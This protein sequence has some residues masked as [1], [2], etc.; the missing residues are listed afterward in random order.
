MVG[1]FLAVQFALPLS[2]Y[3]SGNPLDER[4]AWRMFS[5]IRMVHC[6]ATFHE[7][8]PEGRRRL[9]LGKEVPEVWET[10]VDRG[11]T[12]V[13]REVGEHICTRRAR[14]GP[15]VSVYADVSCPMPDGTRFRPLPAEE[16]LCR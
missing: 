14:L 2:Y 4:F 16:D 6:T 13:I 9:D 11:H 12:R 1:L 7:V 3:A 5:P 10:W 15:E 8:G